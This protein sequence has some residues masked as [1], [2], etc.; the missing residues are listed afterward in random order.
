MER[1]L[2]LY[3]FT[4]NHRAAQCPLLGEKGVVR[5]VA[6][7]PEESGIGDLQTKLI[8]ELIEEKPGSGDTFPQEID[9]VKET[10]EGSGRACMV[11]EFYAEESLRGDTEPKVTGQVN[12]MT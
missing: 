8:K 1:G 10:I 7:A 6:K 3:C 12:L 4:E 9:E 2:C 5:K 11:K